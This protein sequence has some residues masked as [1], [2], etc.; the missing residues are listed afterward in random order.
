M[1]KIGF[2]RVSS[3]QKYLTDQLSV[4]ETYDCE[5]VFYAQPN[6]TTPSNE[7]AVSALLEYLRKDDVV[8]ITSLDKLGVSLSSV[9]SSMT[10]IHKK[11][12]S[13]KVLDNSFDSSTSKIPLS[14]FVEL[15]SVFSELELTLLNRRTAEGRVKAREQGKHMGRPKTIKKEVINN[16]MKQL[17]QGD[18]TVSE[19]A[20][21]NN[22]SRPTVYDI[23][24][25]G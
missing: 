14:T 24:K 19:I 12:A 7:D 1:S 18:M 5:R 23:K 9:L 21:E 17:R 25:K 2:A 13:L 8:V 3:E 4:L 6:S 10:S 20:R 16:V 22:I 11:R 15:L